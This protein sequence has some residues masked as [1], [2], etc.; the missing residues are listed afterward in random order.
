MIYGRIVN[1]GVNEVGQNKYNFELYNAS[2]E[3]IDD[4]IKFKKEEKEKINKSL[5][6]QDHEKEVDNF[7]LVSKNI[8]LMFLAKN[9]FIPI[10][11]DFFFLK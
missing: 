8:P 10:T 9:N 7:Y 6:V 3:M 11:E 5:F 2:S 4:Y 1:L